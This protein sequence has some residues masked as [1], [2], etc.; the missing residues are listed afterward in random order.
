MARLAGPPRSLNWYDHPETG[1]G[2]EFERYRSSA[3]DPVAA[4]L[5]RAMLRLHERI[6]GPAVQEFAVALTAFLGESATPAVVQARP[7]GFLTTLFGLRDARLPHLPVLR[8]EGVA[9]WVAPMRR[10]QPTAAHRRRSGDL[11]PPHVRVGAGR[12]SQRCLPEHLRL[13][14]YYGTRRSAPPSGV[15]T[16]RINLLRLLVPQLDPGVILGEAGI[17]LGVGASRRDSLAWLF[18]LIGLSADR[19]VLDGLL[20]DSGA[21]PVA[22]RCLLDAL[23]RD[24]AALREAG[25]VMPSDLRLARKPEVRRRARAK[26]L[27]PLDSDLAASMV[28]RL[29][30]WQFDS[31]DIITPDRLVEGFAFLHPPLNIAHRFARDESVKHAARY[32]GHQRSHASRSR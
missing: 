9:L 20:Y 7:D 14:A 3:V 29:A 32:L 19:V 16:R 27:K 24:R 21:H 30:L 13:A 12:L 25:R 6:D 2:P 18:D 1:P 11:L 22:L 28:L 15:P 26:L 23:L 8:P 4:Q 10:V 17:D 31:G 5:R